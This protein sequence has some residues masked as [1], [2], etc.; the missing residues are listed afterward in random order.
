MLLPDTKSS[1]R[2]ET[3][4]RPLLQQAFKDAG[5]PVTIQNAQGDKSDPAA[6]GRAGDHQRRQ[7]HPARRTSTRAPARRSSQRQVPRRQG[8]R[9]R[10]PDAEGSADY[11]VSFNNVEVGKLQ[12][13]GLVNCLEQARRRKPA[14]AELNGSPT[15]NNATLFKQGYDSVLNPKYKAGKFD[16]GRRPVRA[17]LGQPEGAD[18]LRADAAEDRATRSTACSRPT[19]ASAT[20]RSR[21]SSSASCADPGHRPGRDAPRGCRTS[22]RATSA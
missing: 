17:R 3:A 13:Q 4:D 7:G 12:G 19:T 22:S 5:V 1:V 18:D 6:A 21:R 8:H 2:W 9:L 16:E 11:Y 20:P 10:P 14:I 15:D